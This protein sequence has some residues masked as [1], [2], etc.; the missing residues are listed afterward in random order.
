MAE[1]TVWQQRREA[2][3]DR[4]TRRH[5]TE[6]GIAH[7]DGGPDV[8]G[9]LYRKGQLLVG[10]GAVDELR[11]ETQHPGVR[12]HEEVNA[13]L[14]ERGVD[15]QCW[16]VPDEIS[17]P[18][19]Q[20][21]LHGRARSA[22]SHVSL[23]H[24]FTGEWIYLGGPATQPELA[25][26][27]SAP[28]EPVP[29]DAPAALSVL[30]TGVASPVNA[31]F[32]EAVRDDDGRSV[33]ELDA[34]HNAYLDSEAGHGTFIC[35]L[36]RQ[37]APGIAMEQRKV[38]DSDG[39]GDD[40]TV[41]R[42]IASSAAP[43]LNLSLGGYT[44]GNRSPRALHEALA[45]LEPGRVVVAAAGNSGRA[46]EFWPAAFPQVI[47]VAAYDPRTGEPAG[48][49]NHG[50]W[51]DVCAPGVGLRS[52]FVDGRRSGDADAPTFAG[53][54]TWSGTSFAAPLVAAEIARRA[55]A[56]PHT[57]ARAVADEL[58]EELG[59]LPRNGYGR[60]FTPSGD[61]TGALSVAA[62]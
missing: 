19:L 40:L 58:L 48:F 32:A 11:R 6:G 15:V 24:V 3:L 9:Y 54:A 10:R 38:L 43:V 13:E 22:G 53:W 52:C 59:P 55:A 47:A 34:D 46:R 35:G 30:D 27:L 14:E 51:V 20:Q 42:G 16:W 4:A 62:V 37:A 60:R 8:E 21:T 45:A 1:K 50:P 41:A 26:V 12:P 28:S 2:A 23:N 31:F 29:A 56:N 44:A 17:V 18:D 57:T 61:V 39:F 7:H 36:V 5:A 49:S 25:P 33:D